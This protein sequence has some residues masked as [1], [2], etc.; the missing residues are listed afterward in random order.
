M[1]AGPPGVPPASNLT[2]TGIGKWS[3]DDFS[4]A[5][6]EG[7]RPDGSQLAEFMPWKAFAGMTDDEIAALWA[8]LRSVPPKDFGGK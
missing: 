4:R 3:R 7:R 8:Y 6:R 1:V 2:P 5:V